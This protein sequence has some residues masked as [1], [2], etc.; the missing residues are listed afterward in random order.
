MS[1]KFM[2]FSSAN[3]KQDATNAVFEPNNG[4]FVLRLRKL[5]RV[6]IGYSSNK[7]L[8]YQLLI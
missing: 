5:I 7:V 1:V 2:N 6:V 3:F 4:G 8:G